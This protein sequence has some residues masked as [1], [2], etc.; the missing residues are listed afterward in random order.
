MFFEIPDRTLQVFKKQA[1]KI[2]A[3]AQAAEDSLHHEIGT[4]SRHGVGWNLPSLHAKAIG[5][6]I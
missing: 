5:Q 3:Q 4:I 1:C 6:V 2:A